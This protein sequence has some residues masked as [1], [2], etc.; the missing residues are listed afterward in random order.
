M[1]RHRIMVAAGDGIGPEIIHEAMKVLDAVSTRFGCTFEL[2]EEPVGGVA[3]ERHGSAL[4]PGA[5]ERASAAAAVLFGAV[6]DPRFDDPAAEV[7][8][9]QAI[10]GLRKGLGLFANLRPVR[11]RAELVGA[12]PLRPDVVRG[13]D[14]VVVRELTGGIYFGRPQE[15]HRTAR[16][17]RAVDTMQY[18]ESEI[19]RILQVSFTQAQSRRGK[20][21]SVDKANVLACGRL[22]RELAD[23]V[24]GE[25]PDVELEHVLVDACTMHLVRD[26]RRFD[27]IVT[28]NMFGDILTDEAAVI[29]GSL[30]LMPSASLGPR[31]E[32]GTHPGLYEPIHGSAPDLAGQG[33]ANPIGTV[34]SVAMMLRLSLGLHAEANVVERA[35]DGAL[36][37]GMRT[38][39]IA[40]DA[41]PG[42][43]TAVMGTAI[44]DR[45][46]RT[47]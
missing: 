32:D 13:T 5:I 9:E 41:H 25:Y 23:E 17:R 4:R 43:P 10:L 2:V 7:R 38:A 8:P 46:L 42:V 47:A 24:A 22:W 12:G 45:V 15:L 16:G 21:A 6:G 40:D 1:Q 33:I 31:R 29:A 28:S 18:A 27:V 26:P 44:A 39:D 11:V 30:G 19:R 20:L 34:L 14:L 36:S 37:A 3:I 35:V